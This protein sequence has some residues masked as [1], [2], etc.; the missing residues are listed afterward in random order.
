MLEIHRYLVRVD[1]R[2]HHVGGNRLGYDREDDFRR[3]QE[4]LA[5]RNAA[6]A[7]ARHARG[8]RVARES[9][10]LSP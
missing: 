9:A 10:A 5:R 4:L 7:T 2:V 8:Q 1:P 6:A 3:V